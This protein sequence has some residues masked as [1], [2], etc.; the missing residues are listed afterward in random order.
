MVRVPNSVY[1]GVLSIGVAGLALLSSGAFTGVAA[2]PEVEVGSLIIDVKSL[3]A[4]CLIKTQKGD[5]VD[6]HCEF[7]AIN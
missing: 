1:G 2:A 5:K 7:K 4:S 6:M 3:P